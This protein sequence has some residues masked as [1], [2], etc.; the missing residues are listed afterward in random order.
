MNQEHLNQLR[1]AL[2]TDSALQSQIRAASTPDE[3]VRIVNQHGCAIT[4]NDLKGESQPADEGELSDA[5]LDG[6]VGGLSASA[7]ARLDQQASEQKSHTEQDRDRRR[8]STDNIQKF[9]DIIHGMNPK[10]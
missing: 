5:E 2:K 10:I 6:V 8:A 7:L 3:I 4:V 1:A 9:L